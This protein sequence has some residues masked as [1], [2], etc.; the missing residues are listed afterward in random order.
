MAKSSQLLAAS[1]VPPVTLTTVLGAEADLPARSGLTHVQFRRFAGCPVCNLHLRS[2]ARRHDDLVAAR[3]HELVFF[4]STQADLLPHVTDLPFHVIADPGMVM[5]R[6][7]GVEASRRVMLDPR[8]W[9]IITRATLR[10]LWLLL[11]RESTS[12]ALFPAGGRYGQP[13]D[14]LIAADGE[15]LDSNHGAHLND[16]WSVDD[17][18]ARAARHRAGHG[19]GEVV[20]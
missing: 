20:R 18:L 11:R 3:V 14:F 12:P 13:A 5:Y 8:A 4:H 10:S 15:V 19:P 2:F 16:H 1:G 17:V 7:F 9:R 6:R